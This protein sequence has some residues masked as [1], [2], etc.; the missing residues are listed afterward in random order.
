MFDGRN[1]FPVRRGASCLVGF[2][3]AFSAGEG[4]EIAQEVTG[5]EAGCQGIGAA[6]GSEV[7]FLA[8]VHDE[9]GGS[10]ET[11]LFEAVWEFLEQRCVGLEGNDDRL[12]LGDEFGERFVGK[13][14]GLG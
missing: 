11:F 1:F 4:G 3:A 10:G 9:Q 13:L 2:A 8:I 6:V 14:G 5:Y 7:E 12:A